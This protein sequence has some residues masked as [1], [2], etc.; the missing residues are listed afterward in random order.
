MVR[1]IS[2]EMVVMYLGSVVEQ[3]PSDDVFFTP[4]HPYSQAL[5]KANPLADP[6]QEKQRGHDLIKGEVPSPVNLP[7]G[8]RFVGRC[9]KASERCHSERPLLQ[10]VGRDHLVACHLYD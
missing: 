4:K 7:P 3:G 1:Y 8:C 10:P 5:T 6:K 2:D 9:P